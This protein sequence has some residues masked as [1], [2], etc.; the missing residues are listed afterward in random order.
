M[1]AR[2]AGGHPGLV[3]RGETAPDFAS[4]LKRLI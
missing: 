3:P 1:S 4:P 2:K